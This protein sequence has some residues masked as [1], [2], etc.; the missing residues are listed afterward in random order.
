MRLLLPALTILCGCVGTGGG[1]RPDEYSGTRAPTYVE[2]RSACANYRQVLASVPFPGEAVA[3]NVRAGQVTIEFAPFLQGSPTQLR[4]VQATHN[5]FVEPALRAAR[6]LECRPGLG[7]LP[8][9]VVF[10]FNNGGD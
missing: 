10:E 2:A 9:R 4:V 5:V 1:T 8:V 6:R 3:A 7:S